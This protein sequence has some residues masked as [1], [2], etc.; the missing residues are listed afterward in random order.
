VVCVGL[1]TVDIFQRVERLPGVDE[2]IQ[3]H[4][5][6][7]AAGGPAA[8]AAV[9]AAALGARV[10]LVTA[11][12]RHPLAQ[13]V[14][15]D[16]G[17]HDVALLDATP[18][19]PRPPAISSVTVLEA[20]GQRSVVSVNAAGVDAPAPPAMRRLVERA[21]VVLIDGHHPA[22]ATAAVHAA[23]AVGC[24]VV[25]DAGSWRPVLAEV[26]PL[27]DV[28]ACSAAF[29]LPGSPG[30]APAPASA[31]ACDSTVHGSTACGSTACGSTADG[32]TACG[33]TVHG[34]TAD[35]NTAAAL[36]GDG[37]GHVAVTHGPDPVRWWSGGR[38]GSV[39]V[40]PVAA[41]D[42]AGA[43][44]VF[45]GALAVAVAR[46]RGITDLAAALRYA[47]SVAGIRVSHVG[48]RRWLTD[49]RM[50]GLRAGVAGPE[51]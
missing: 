13:L 34:S 47:V 18:H 37:V 23:G 5:S 50:G 21:D 41:V 4:A 35:D 40:P 8:N 10:T 17:A 48:P 49:P 7:I 25:V 26:L 28:V 6:D 30:P 46:D 45:H 36:L 39:A 31:R 24:P 43:G 33:S 22:L 51:R 27:A 11:V 38:N 44:D 19:L 1:A 9:T 14:T 32:S 20:T 2:K 15:G 16:L 42:T 3:A 12:G 29:R